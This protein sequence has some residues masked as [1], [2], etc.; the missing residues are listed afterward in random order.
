VFLEKLRPYDYRSVATCPFCFARALLPREE[1]NCPH[2]VVAFQD[3]HWEWTPS[4]WLTCYGFRYRRAELLI[5]LANSPCIHAKLALGTRTE[6]RVEAYYCSRTWLAADLRQRFKKSL[7]PGPTCKVCGNTD[8]VTSENG[9][10][11]CW[12]CGKLPALTPQRLPQK[13]PAEPKNRSPREHPVN[14]LRRFLDSVGPGE[15][16]DI[17]ALKKFLAPC[18]LCFSGNNVQKMS[19]GKLRRLERP[20]WR[21]PVLE[22]LIERHGRVAMGATRAELHLWRVNLEQRTAECNAGYGYRE[23]VKHEVPMHVKPNR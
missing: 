10:L 18:W 12:L 15:V 6:P 1:E 2:F 9:E 3:G 23:L 19:A 5:A 21:P 7:I 17:S 11:I 13:A 4:R 16:R 22:F 14:G 20:K 8:A